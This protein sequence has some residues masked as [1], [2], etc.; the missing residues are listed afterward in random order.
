MLGYPDVE[1]L[2]TVNVLDIFE[3]PDDREQELSRLEDNDNVNHFEMQL[4]QPDGNVIW[5][6]DTFR[7]VRDSDG[8][9]LHFEG[10]L[11]N[12]TEQVQAEQDL[13]ESRE[14]L[15][16]ILDSLDA[17]IYVSDMDTYEILF[18]NQHMRAS[19]D[20]DLVGKIC[21]QVFRGEPG[22][23]P[24]CT[25]SQL[26]DSGGRPDGV[27]TWEGQNPITG[28]WYLNQDRAIE[29]VDGRIVR[30]QIATD[31]SER[32]RAEQALQ[33]SEAQFRTLFESS[34]VGIGVTDQQGNLLMFNEAMLEPG[35]YS[36]TDI[37]E[38]GNVAALY[39]K[40]D[41]RREALERFREQG[42][43]NDFPVQFKRKDG[44]PYDALLS[45]TPIQFKGQACIQAMVED[46]TERVRAEAAERDQRTLAEAL[47]ET[48][49]TLNRS[50]D[51]G[52]V[53]ERILS[54]AGRVVPHD[55]ATVILIE[56]GKLHIA[57]SHGYKER[58][59]SIEKTLSTLNMQEPGN[60]KQIFE[61]REPVVI[62]DVSA[63]PHWN[64]L[65]GTE[66]LRSSVGAPL[67]IKDNVVGFLLLD[68]E[69]PGFFTP[70]HAE[71]LQAF[72]SQAALAI[73]N[74]RL[75]EETQ[76]LA[77]FNQ[78]IVQSMTEGIVVENGDGAFNYANPA[79]L[80]LLGYHL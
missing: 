36:K 54:I 17:D 1:E 66:W 42:F 38:L 71:R 77:A 12:I 26:I 27:V 22:P 13:N 7:V 32:V 25:N 60:L 79:A 34:P 46:I 2:L 24:H 47:R 56:D 20:G 21:W 11:E 64:T 74:A 72:A 62:P 10:S 58:G 48:A 4:R 8:Q 63:Y 59:L 23:C 67:L 31:I 43:L 33:E 35:G 3:N 44:S 29:W 49:E 37:Q 30:L 9:I 78:N 75:Y 6:R 39:H 50:L 80:K 52:S 41:Q 19:F 69:T 76:Q 15:T 51:Y 68:S 55:T 18:M 14:R 40:P 5:V 45:L 70:L 57:G 28:D 53:L 61:S 73:E 16:T 65:P